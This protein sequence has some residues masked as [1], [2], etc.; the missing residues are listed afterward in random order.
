M[1]D[2]REG[3]R[4]QVSANGRGQRIGHGRA[5]VP[6]GSGEPEKR[7]HRDGDLHVVS[8]LLYSTFTR[9]VAQVSW[10]SMP[11]VAQNVAR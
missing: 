11:S 6:T 1:L 8:P 10:P 7:E 4:L 2:R 5:F 3:L 9:T